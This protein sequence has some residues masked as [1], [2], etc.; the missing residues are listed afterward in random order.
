MKKALSGESRCEVLAAVQA[1]LL[2]CACRGKTATT[3]INP[4]KAT[5]PCDPKTDTTRCKAEQQK[6]LCASVSV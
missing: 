5:A 4:A 2:K 3:T 6:L 1:T